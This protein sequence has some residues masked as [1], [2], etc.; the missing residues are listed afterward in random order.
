MIV[1]RKVEKHNWG[2]KFYFKQLSLGAK[3]SVTPDADAESLIAKKM[4]VSLLK[5][6]T[7]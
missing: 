3:R 6:L 5:G 7:A 1:Q 4:K 2:F